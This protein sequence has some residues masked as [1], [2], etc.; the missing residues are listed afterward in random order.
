[1]PK[2]WERWLY[3]SSLPEFSQ[4]TVTDVLSELATAISGLEQQSLS[5]D[6]GEALL[7]SIH[8]QTDRHK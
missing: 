5:I 6:Y 7:F 8:L 1:M 2:F 4:M 3:T